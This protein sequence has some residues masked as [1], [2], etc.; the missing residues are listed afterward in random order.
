MKSHVALRFNEDGY[1]CEVVPFGTLGAGLWTGH[2]IGSIIVLGM[3]A[4]GLV[5]VPAFRWFFVGT[6]IGGG[7]AGYLLWRLHQPR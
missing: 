7:F 5:G 6:M 1:P 2:P 4:M 3:L